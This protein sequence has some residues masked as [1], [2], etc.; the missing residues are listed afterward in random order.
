MTP[1]LRKSA[2]YLLL[3][4]AGFIIYSDSLSGEFMCDDYG[5][6]LAH[7]QALDS[8]NWKDLWTAYD[9]R[10]VGGLT[11]ALNYK[12]NGLNVFSF[13]LFNI[14]IHILNAL[15]VYLLILQILRLAPNN[16]PT[17][18]SRLNE[19][20]L[21]AA[22]IFLSHP[23]EI[24]AVSYITQRFTSLAAMFYLATLLSYGKA[25]LTNKTSYYVITLLCF[26]MSLLSKSANATLIV[27]LAVY[28]LF[29][30][31]A[32][33]LKK[34]H[35]LVLFSAGAA[36]TWFMLMIA[37]NREE[38]KLCMLPIENAPAHWQY[39]LTMINVCRSYLGLLFFPLRLSHSYDDRIVKHLWE[40]P[41]LISILLIIGIILLTV[42][43]FKR[44]RKVL[45]FSIIF[46]Y[47]TLAPY[48]VFSFLYAKN[49]ADLMYDHWLYLP[50]AGFAFFFSAGISQLIKSKHRARQTLVVVIA[51]LS[52]LTFQRNNVWKTEIA[53]W[54]NVIR[55]N[56]KSLLHY[57]AL[58]RSYQRKGLTAQAYEVYAAGAKL[59]QSSP[60]PALPVDLIYLSRLYNNLGITAFQL[61]KDDQALTCSLKA[62]E[63]DD[64]NISARN[65]LGI[66]FFE[67]KRYKEAA[68][69]LSQYLRLAPQDPHAYYY[70]G[71]SL[72]KLDRGAKAKQ[73]L[74]KALSLFK[75]G[76]NL[77]MIKEIEQ[78]LILHE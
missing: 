9:T 1:L 64:K 32:R 3:I 66:M 23:I 47:L 72:L 26:L 44:K 60:P 61:G 78:L 17:E 19:I 76:N 10:I 41:T 35:G 45:C 75:A 14:V 62:L 7:E 55:S 34:N 49:G 20:A 69:S 30:F 22:L 37:Q 15:L 8:F 54:Q 18:I 39:F 12:L 70:R 71:R 27:T 38:G 67:L 4:I 63:H 40:F 77:T 11:F 43:L 48:L 21:F 6:I 73:D 56:P 57:L 68:N 53:L 74:E 24:Q 42:F 31:Q 16:G 5:S 33:K 65:N 28:E 50:M 36:L 51:I 25:R 29:F 46:F 2:P 52:T 59:H 58:G 13:H